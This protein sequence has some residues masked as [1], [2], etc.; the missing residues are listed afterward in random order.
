MQD[1]FVYSWKNKV[2]GQLYIGWH[3]G[4]SNDGYICSREELKS[5]IEKS[6]ESFERFIIAN[7]S[8]KDMVALEHALLCAVDAKNSTAFYNAHNGGTGYCGGH[9]IKTRLKMSRSKMGRKRPA[10]V[11]QKMKE[12]TGEKSSGFG[13]RWITNGLDSRK[14]KKEDSV[15]VGWIFGRLAPWM[16]RAKSTETKIKMSIARTGKHHSPET[17]LKFKARRPSMLGRKHSE[18]TKA[19]LR[20]AR[21]TRKLLWQ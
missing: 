1:A 9:S 18:E 20:V 21:S 11:V 16:K 17:L 10:A 14:I 15:P 6:P 5:E 2:S 12:R 8:V 7:G 13:S 3:K 19:K 4:A